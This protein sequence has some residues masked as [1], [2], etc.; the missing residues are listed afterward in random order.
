MKGGF[1]LGLILT[2][3]LITI[4]LL[5]IIDFLIGFSFILTVGYSVRSLDLSLDGDY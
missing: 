4:D 1:C 3:F 5:I 2:N